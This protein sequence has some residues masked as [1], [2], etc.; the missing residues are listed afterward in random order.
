MQYYRLLQLK[1][2]NK[3]SKYYNKSSIIPMKIRKKKSSDI[4]K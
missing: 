3:S 1:K 2:Y 4:K